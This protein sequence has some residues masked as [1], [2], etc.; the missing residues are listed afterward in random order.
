MFNYFQHKGQA[1]LERTEVRK[2]WT[3]EKEQKSGGRCKKPKKQ[4][5]NLEGTEKA[6]TRR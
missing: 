2:K 3:E 1:S 5:K 4:N 6:K